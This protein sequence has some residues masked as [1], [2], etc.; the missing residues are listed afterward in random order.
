M[1]LGYSEADGLTF[2]NLNW[3]DAD[4]VLYACASWEASDAWLEKAQAPLVRPAWDVD[5]Y[6]DMEAAERAQTVMVITTDPI[7]A[8]PTALVAINGM[9]ALAA[10]AAM[11]LTLVEP[12]DG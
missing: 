8:S 10:V 12:Q 2:S 6:I 1:C 4:G 3:Q 5:N 11:G 9:D 7:P